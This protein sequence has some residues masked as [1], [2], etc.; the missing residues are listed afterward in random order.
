MTTEGGGQAD[1]I[2][3]LR[4]PDSWRSSDLCARWRAIVT[5]A[6][7]SGQVTQSMAV[8]IGQRTT[9]R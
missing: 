4:F 2:G 9:T 6:M 5:A 1:G 7:E 3:W 8:S